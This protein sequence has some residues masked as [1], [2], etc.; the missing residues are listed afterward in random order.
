VYRRIPTQDFRDV[1][2]TR[3]PSSLTTVPVV[4]VDPINQNNYYQASSQNPNYIPNNNSNFN[5]S[6][7]NNQYMQTPIPQRRVSSNNDFVT[8]VLVGES[9]DNK[10]AT[11]VALLSTLSGNGN[12]SFAS[13]VIVGENFHKNKKHHKN[14]LTQHHNNLSITSQSNYA[15]TLPSK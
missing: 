8:G 5:Y 2:I 11:N 3:L 9:L 7:N 6:Y 13:G 15:G 4:S 14:L 10:T 12:N 1:E